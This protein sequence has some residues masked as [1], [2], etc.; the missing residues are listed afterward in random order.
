[1]LYMAV[2]KDNGR[3][4]IATVDGLD[5]Y[6][7]MLIFDYM[8]H[9]LVYRHTLDAGYFESLQHNGIFQHALIIVLM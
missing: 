4:A 9:S 7:D 3:L 2:G 1:M 6:I 8:K 5:M